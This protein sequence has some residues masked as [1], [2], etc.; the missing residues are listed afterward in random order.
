MKMPGMKRTAKA[1]RAPRV[2]ASGPSGGTF[3]LLKGL[4]AAAPKRAAPTAPRASAAGYRG[5]H[6]MKGMPE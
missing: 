4:K 1:S 6:M 2:I 3:N 5:R